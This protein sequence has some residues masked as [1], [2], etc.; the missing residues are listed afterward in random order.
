MMVAEKALA[1]ISRAADRFKV[2]NS[3]RRSAQKL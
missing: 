2:R 1:S 3:S